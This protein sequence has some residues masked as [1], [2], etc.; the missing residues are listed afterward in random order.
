MAMTDTQVVEL[1]A[2]YIELLK[3]TLTHALWYDQEVG[4]PAPSA[5]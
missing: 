4:L 3:M 2:R 1:R 5:G